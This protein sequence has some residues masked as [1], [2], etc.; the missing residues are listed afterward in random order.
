MALAQGGPAPVFAA[1]ELRHILALGPWPP[2]PRADPT[3]RVS[4]KV[5]AIEL[6]RRL[7]RDPRMSPLGYIGC[8][9]CHQPD[10]SF[11][12]L[13]ARAHG[14]ADLPRHTP[15]LANPRLQHWYGW[16]GSSDSLWMAS[17]RPMLDAREFDGNPASITRIFERDPELAACYRKV[18]R[19][20]PRRGRERTVVNVGKALAAFVETLVTG[21]TP[22]DD[23]R[24]ALAHKD[25]ALSAPYPL[26]AQ[27]GLKLFVGKAQCVACHNG[28]NFSDGEFHPGA[29]SSAG[30][31]AAGTPLAVAFA[32]SDTGRLES[33]QNLKASRYNLPG[34]LQRRPKPCQRR[35]HAP[36]GRPGKHAREIPHPKSAQC[37][38]YGTVH[39]QR[40][41]RRPARR[42]TAHAAATAGSD[43]AARGF[44]AATGGRPGRVPGHAHRPVWGTP[45]VGFGERG[46]L[47]LGAF[48]IQSF[49]S[50][51]SSTS[52]SFTF[53]HE[54]SFVTTSAA[55]DST[56][57]ASMIASAPNRLSRD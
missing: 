29:S 54:T 18:F 12:D 1:E 16:G 49:M 44:D 11:T 10:R 42:V 35:G 50:R 56:A 25:V 32:P 43:S 17:I 34:A 53:R 24:D 30:I 37:G 3:N 31:F 20:S 46:P 45:A 27:R 38:G 23:F 14:L 8:V 6:G 2:S 28:P 55:P 52:T 57:E 13:K 7:F 19:E 33:A 15:A 36:V 5:Q 48:S 4:G 40:Q 9:T 22:F 39:A 41:Y 26:A 47:P 51:N 21:R